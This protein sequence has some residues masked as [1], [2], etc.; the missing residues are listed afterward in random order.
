MQL[1]LFIDLSLFGNMRNLHSQVMPEKKHPSLFPVFHK[2]II[3]PSGMYVFNSPA[4]SWK[5]LQ[6][7]FL[8]ISRFS[9]SGNILNVNI[10]R[11]FAI[12]N[13]FF[14]MS[15]LWRRSGSCSICASV[16]V[17]WWPEAH[18]ASYIM[19]ICWHQA[20][21]WVYYTWMEVCASSVPNI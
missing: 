20:Y 16:R 10:Q 12:A 18:Y 2:Q 13:I 11:K 14:F 15:R 4:S 6:N 17:W 19:T 3:V 5:V 21:F 1:K 9:L 7:L 8:I